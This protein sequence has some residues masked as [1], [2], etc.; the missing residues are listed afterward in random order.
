MERT[1]ISVGEAQK[2]LGEIKEQAK[3]IT[4]GK[5]KEKISALGL[6]PFDKD[7]RGIIPEMRKFVQYESLLEQDALRRLHSKNGLD[8]KAVMEKLEGIRRNMQ[9]LV[10]CAYMKKQEKINRIMSRLTVL[11]IF[12]MIIQAIIMG[13]Q[14]ARMP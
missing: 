12:L 14:L 5:L 1:L 6:N 10:T 7:L 9:F 13:I 8:L 11:V 4:D 2:K 3:T